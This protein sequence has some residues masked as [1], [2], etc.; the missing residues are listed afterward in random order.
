MMATHYGKQVILLINEYDVPLAKA[1]E[2]NTEENRY[3]VT[4]VEA[5]VVDQG[6]Y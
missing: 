1:S 2:L 3:T 4:G 6:W 5:G